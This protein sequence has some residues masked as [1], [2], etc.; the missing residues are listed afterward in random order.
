MKRYLILA[1]LCEQRRTD[2]LLTTNG[3]PQTGTVQTDFFLVDMLYI[4]DANNALATSYG[5][6]YG[7]MYM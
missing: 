5:A 6:Y 7:V 4:N 3:W 1:V 2:G